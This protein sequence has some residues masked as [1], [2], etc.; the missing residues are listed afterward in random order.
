MEPSIIAICVDKPC[1]GIVRSL[2]VSAWSS[3][4]TL[5]KSGRE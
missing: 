5:D 3:F 2:V 4:Q 1:T